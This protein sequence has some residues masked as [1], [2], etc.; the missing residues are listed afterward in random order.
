MLTGRVPFKAE[1]QVG[2]AMKHVREP[3]PDVQRLRPEIS[4][5]LA[6]VVER[7]TAKERKNRYANVDEM[8][9]DLEQALAI[10]VARSRPPH[11]R[12]DVG[13]PRAAAQVGG[14]RAG[15]LAQPAAVG[16]DARAHRDRRRAGH[17]R[18]R[19][20]APRRTS[21]P[22]PARRAP[23]A[24]PGR[25]ARPAAKDFDP[26]GDGEEHDY[27]VARAIDDDPRHALVDRELHAGRRLRRASPASACT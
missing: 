21:S 20:C 4:A 14:D 6:A 11:R 27:E 7:A 26:G 3:M 1:S 19:C 24:R 16:G 25:R 15:A 9:D 18:P 10:E 2:V 22:S 12:G 23:A 5:A 17:G 8:L 13:D